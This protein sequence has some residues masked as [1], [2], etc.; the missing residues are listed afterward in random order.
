MQRYAN[1]VDLEKCWKMTIYLQ[2]LASIQPR[3]SP[4]KF[5]PACLPP[6]PHSFNYVWALAKS[7]PVMRAYSS[8]EMSS[9]A[10]LQPAVQEPGLKGS[11]AEGPNHS[12]FSAQNSVH[13]SVRIWGNFVRI[14]QKLWN[15]MKFERCWPFSKIFREMPTN[16]HQN[17]WKIPWKLLKNNGFC[18]NFSRNLK[19]LIEFLLKSLPPT[20][21]VA[22]RGVS[23]AAA[24][25]TVAI[26]F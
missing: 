22:L 14:H 21:C 24:D 13:N 6:P 26:V 7:V 15:L 19:K 17:R 9:C 20:P 4:P 12:N 2:R 10:S 11:I 23:S 5:G 25:A 3:T 8:T 18:R 1:L 16:F